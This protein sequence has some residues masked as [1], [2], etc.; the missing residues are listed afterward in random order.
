MKGYGKSK[1]EK[2]GSF[3]IHRELRINPSTGNQYIFFDSNDEYSFKKE[4]PSFSLSQYERIVL[5][6]NKE[7]F[8]DKKQ[9][10][11]ELTKDFEIIILN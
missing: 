9:Y 3:Q 6:R 11:L 10:K 1:K 7:E 4:N 8:K 2:F 5:R